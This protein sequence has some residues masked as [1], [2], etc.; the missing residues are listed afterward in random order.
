MTFLNL[1]IFHPHFLNLAQKLKWKSPFK[2]KNNQF[3]R[4]VFHGFPKGEYP[5]RIFYSGLIFFFL[6]R[7]TCGQ[8]GQIRKPLLPQR[9]ML[10]S[11]QGPIFRQFSWNRDIRQ[12]WGTQGKIIV[13][14]LSE[15]HDYLMKSQEILSILHLILHMWI[16][17]LLIAKQHAKY[18]MCGGD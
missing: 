14:Y 15:R 9:W 3:Y 18:H 8:R 7:I 11:R 6:K 4:N 2:W 16:E 13:S 17:H 5:L 1:G 12:H 10:G